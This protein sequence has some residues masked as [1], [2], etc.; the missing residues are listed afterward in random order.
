MNADDNSM[1]INEF[2]LE[3][4]SQEQSPIAHVVAK[5]ASD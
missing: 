2:N 3:R 4:L 1:K 5:W